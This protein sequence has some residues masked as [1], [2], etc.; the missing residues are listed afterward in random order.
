MIDAIILAGGLGTRLSGIANGVI[1]PMMPINGRPFLEILLDS[2]IRQN[3][4]RVI[5]AVSHQHHQIT[6][7]FGASYNGLHIDYSVE[8]QP[9]GTGGAI[10]LALEKSRGLNVLVL[11]GDTYFDVN[12]EHLVQRHELNSCDITMAVKRID[13]S[14][15]YGSVVIDDYERIIGFEE[16]NIKH[17]VLINGGVYVLNSAKYIEKT[18]NLDVFSFEKDFLEKHVDSALFC[19]CEQ[20]A[21]FID[22][23]IPADYEK[24]NLELA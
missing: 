23:G 21:Y 4:Q 1:K 5:I 17:D 24:A 14:D 22:I 7:Y 12:I 13:Y 15:R 9:K 6:D 11:N 8:S 18:K 2:L 10:N 3:I 19:A 20:N 16:K